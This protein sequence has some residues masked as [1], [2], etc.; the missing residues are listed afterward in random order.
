MWDT[1]IPRNDC[2]HID[3]IIFRVVRWF[4]ITCRWNKWSWLIT[5][6]LSDVIISWCWF[7]YTNTWDKSY[8]YIYIYIYIYIKKTTLMRDRR[9][10][11]TS[12]WLLYRTVFRKF[13][14]PKIP[15]WSF[16][17]PPRKAKQRTCLQETFLGHL[18][19]FFGPRGD[20]GELYRWD[21]RRNEKLAGYMYPYIYNIIY[22]HIIHTCCNYRYEEK[23]CF[24]YVLQKHVNEAIHG[25][26]VR[27]VSATTRWASGLPGTWQSK[28]SCNVVT[29]TPVNSAPPPLKIGQIGLPKWLIEP[30]HFHGFILVIITEWNGHFHELVQY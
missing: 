3:I 4:Q 15:H 2:S 17:K 25:P 13:P 30:T 14:Y 16:R 24:K 18:G 28:M 27:L 9:F 26:N 22:T 11:P 23:T 5:H 8:S 20:H 29:T 21:R 7:I 10:I 6:T 19:I 1:K 12:G